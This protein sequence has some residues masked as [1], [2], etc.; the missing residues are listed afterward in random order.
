MKTIAGHCQKCGAP[1][2]QEQIW[3]GI[4]P[5][6]ITPM[7]QCWNLPKIETSTETI[8]NNILEKIKGGK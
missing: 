5:P 4:T 2:Y 7:C 1:Y 3:H 8:A 6:P